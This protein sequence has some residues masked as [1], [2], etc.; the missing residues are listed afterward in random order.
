[1]SYLNEEKNLISKSDLIE[2]VGLDLLK[3][4]S[5]PIPEIANLSKGNIIKKPLT[6]YD[7]NGKPLFLD[8][9]LKRG[10]KTIGTV[11]TA[12]SKIL[13]KP[14]F[15]YQLGDSRLNLV[16]SLSKANLKIKKMYPQARIFERK[17]VCYSYPKLGVM[18][19]VLVNR[20]KKRIIFDLPTLNTVKV[21]SPDLKIEG[22][23]AWSFYDAIKTEERKKR[24][25]TYKKFEK[26]RLEAPEKIRKKLKVSKTLQTRDFISYAKTL[27]PLVNWFG[28][29]KLQFCSHYN[30]PFGLVIPLPKGGHH[31][32]IL[33]AQERWDYCAV[34]TCQMILCYYRYYY[35]QDD[36]APD[37]GYTAGNGCPSDQSAGYES[38]TSNHLNAT[39][40]NN[41]T[42]E[43]AKQ[44]IDQLKPLKTGISGHARAAAGYYKSIFLGTETKML[45]VYDPW[46]WNTDLTAGGQVSWED[47]DSITHTNFIYTDLQY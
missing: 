38:L 17:I 25:G 29:R 45:F 26:V 30:N 12:A 33:H 10:T 44:Q 18:Y 40:D 42:W 14:V 7:I 23:Y 27:V 39:F 41:P 1:M 47:W 20:E 9:L 13:G 43:K 8:Y 15:R 28:G 31:C 6:V 4:R 22:V 34:A 32:F 3:N 37:L 11:R 36:I 19:N 5:S 24:L 21:A 16:S 2:H 35:S 46:P